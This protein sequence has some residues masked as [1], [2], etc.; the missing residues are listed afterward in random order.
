MKKALDEFNTFVQ[1]ECGYLCDCI[2]IMNKASSQDVNVEDLKLN[3]EEAVGTHTE[4]IESCI[5]SMLDSL[6]PD[7][8]VFADNGPL[9]SFSDGE[10]VY[11]PKGVAKIEN[12]AFANQK[13]IKMVEI[14]EGVTEIGERA[15]EGCKNLKSITLPEGLT[16]I[17]KLAFCDCSS[18]ESIT[19]PDSVTYIGYGAFSGCTSLRELVL[20]F[21]G[22][23]NNPDVQRWSVF[24]NIFGD[25]VRD[26]YMHRDMVLYTTSDG[27]GYTSQNSQYDA[28][29]D[30]FYYAI[31]QSLRR[32]V[33]TK[34]EI[35]PDSAF[36]NC[37]LIEEIILP[38]NVQEVYNNAFEGCKKLKSITL[39]E[40][41][42]KIWGLAFC[43]CSSLESITIP[44][45]V[46]YIGYGAFS[47]CTSLK[48]MVLPFVGQATN[49]KEQRWS[50]FGNIFGD[51]VRDEYMHRDMVLYTTSD[52][53]GY[54]SQNS[55]DDAPDDFFYYA[56]P[57]SLRRVVITKQETI[58][59]SAFK[60]C[61]LIEEI[62]LPD[63]VQEVYNNAFEGCDS[64]NTLSP[65]WVDTQFAARGECSDFD[66]KK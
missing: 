63:N 34:Q 41:L 54:T 27:S 17:G 1:R 20:P 12:S 7:E 42:T 37:D 32:V 66:I 64:L 3:I 4:R 6:V 61:D 36:K 56:I 59:D 60:N 24:G 51:Y 40:G 14:P 43:D 21:V 11:I 26:G 50:V 39:P 13:C 18:L 58:P 2:D 31:P 16:Q 15:F 5:L 62:I 44:D 8:S 29:D 49:P 48:E 35:I 52:G 46:T 55:E 10:H 22:R 53:S 23:G 9:K 28:P 57:Q 38:D 25:Y 47:G 19:I 45:S 30:F 65:M 33:I